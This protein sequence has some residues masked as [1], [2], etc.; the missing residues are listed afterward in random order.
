MTI[1]NREGLIKALYAKQS[2]AYGKHTIAGVIGDTYRIRDYNTTILILGSDGG[3]EYFNN[4]FYSK[5]TSKLQ[6]LLKEI[7]N[8]VAPERRAYLFNTNP[9]RAYINEGYGDITFDKEGYILFATLKKG[10]AITFISPSVLN[11]FI[12]LKIGGEWFDTETNL[13][14]KQEVPQ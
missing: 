13:L 8:I 3:I 11:P 7:F 9:K 2:F 5:T 4:T 6:N 12:S 1:R 10:G 14:T